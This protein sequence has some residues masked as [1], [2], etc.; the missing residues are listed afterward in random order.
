MK[1]SL[2]LNAEEASPDEQINKA[3][4]KYVYLTVTSAKSLLL[5]MLMSLDQ[6]RVKWTNS[7]TERILEHT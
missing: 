5:R 3:H 6:F 4:I 7:Q 1:S 2:L